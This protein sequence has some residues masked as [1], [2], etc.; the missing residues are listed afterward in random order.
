MINGRGGVREQCPGKF[1]ATWTLGINLPDGVTKLRE[2]EGSDIPAI[3]RRV[4]PDLHFVQIHA[5][6]WMSAALPPD[7]PGACGGKSESRRNLG[8]NIGARRLADTRLVC[9]PTKPEDWSSHSAVEFS[10]SGKATKQ[11]STCSSW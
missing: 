5:P 9:R 1:I 10:W 7:C 8:P 2:W 3:I 11:L 6:D 4:R